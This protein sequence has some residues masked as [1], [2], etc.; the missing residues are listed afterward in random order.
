MNSLPKG[1][2]REREKAGNKVQVSEEGLTKESLEKTGWA[3]DEHSVAG[4][5]LLLIFE[6]WYKCYGFLADHLAPK[7][8]L[9]LLQLSGT[10]LT[11]FRTVSALA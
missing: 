2:R 11:A 4:K 1:P 5:R 9:P 7:L 3:M 10:T 6:E 8:S